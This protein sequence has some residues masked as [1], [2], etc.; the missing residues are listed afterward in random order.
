VFHSG[1]QND[2]LA[3]FAKQQATIEQIRNFNDCAG[4]GQ[5]C[6]ANCTLYPSAK[7]DPSKHLFTHSVI[8]IR[9][10]SHR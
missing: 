8:S 3:R 5:P 4:E 1:G 10:K 7:G 9:R 6:G 2:R